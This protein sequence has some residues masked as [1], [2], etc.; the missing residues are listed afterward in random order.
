M[1]EMN[2]ISYVGH[3]RYQKTIA[4]VRNQYFFPKMEKDIVED[5]DKRMES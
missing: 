3:L 2:S 5:M 4:T 1:N